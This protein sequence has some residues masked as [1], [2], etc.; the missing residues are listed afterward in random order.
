[1]PVVAMEY[2]VHIWQVSPQQIWMWCKESNTYFC[3][4][5]NFAYGG[6]INQQSFSNPHPCAPFY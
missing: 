6:E 3:R 4:I 1:M 5:E 2:H